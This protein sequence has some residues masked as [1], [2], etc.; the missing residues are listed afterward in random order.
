MRRLIVS[1][2][3]NDYFRNK[4]TLFWNFIFPIVL[5]LI[6]VSIFGGM[7]SSMNLRI[8][9]V[10][11]SKILKS[12]FDNLPSG[13][14]VIEIEEPE[15]ALKYGRVDA[16][17]IIPENFDSL[18]SQALFLSKTKVRVP[19]RITV[20]Y[21]AE[22]QESIA[23]ANIISSILESLDLQIRKLKEVK[24]EYKKKER[25]NINYSHFVFPAILLVGIMS[26]G[27]FT[28]PYQLVLYK[29]QGILKRLLASPLS[30]YGYLVVL[31]VCGLFAMTMTS[32][33][34]MVL[35]RVV[36]GVSRLSLNFF[37]GV[38]FSFLT[39]LSISFLMVSLFKSFSALG[40]ASQVFNQIF[41]FMGGFY[42][43]VSNVPWP[44]KA[45]VLGNPA[46]YLVDYL[47]GNLGY[48]MI[49]S[50]HLLV[51]VIWIAVSLILF[52]FRW[53]QVMVV[54]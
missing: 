8:G 36:Y 5:Y 20:A 34:I 44:L 46:T 19:V 27:L 25:E 12:V 32:T 16:C 41:M 13:I 51:P 48:K 7:P 26:V 4:G 35:A 53:R 39:F 33:G 6:L 24:V 11:D 22:R 52:L 3:K 37:G 31:I 30:K 9:I 1:I 47:R 10:G 38:L 49:Y 29:E 14:K 15:K 18:F 21:A 2:L 40:A 23:L 43:D 42:F 54:E 45:F 28:V 50:N 17:I